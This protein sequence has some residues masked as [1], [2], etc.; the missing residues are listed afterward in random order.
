MVPA[1]PEA[2]EAVAGY[3]RGWAGSWCRSLR[4]SV[5]R[6]G[7]S[8]DAFA[9]RQGNRE[10][11]PPRVRPYSQTGEDV[12]ETRVITLRASVWYCLPE[13][14]LVTLIR[15]EKTEESEEEAIAP[16]PRIPR[17]KKKKERVCPQQSDEEEDKKEFPD[18]QKPKIRLDENSKSGL[19]SLLQG[20]GRNE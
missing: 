11:E 18:P 13:S 8:A 15:V 7:Q 19:R 5:S 4:L 20:L 9:R 14:S 6:G 3:G 12:D 16:L 1:R 2:R 10:G 17:R